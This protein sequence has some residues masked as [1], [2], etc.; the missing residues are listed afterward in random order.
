[1]LSL[2]HVVPGTCCPWDVLSWNVLYVYSLSNSICTA[3]MYNWNIIGTV[4]LTINKVISTVLHTAVI[5]YL[6]GLNFTIHTQYTHM[7]SVIVKL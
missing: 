6:A 1:M 2:G 5:Q 4:L 3:D 7:L